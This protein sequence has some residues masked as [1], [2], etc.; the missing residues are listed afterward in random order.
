LKDLF[1]KFFSG[2]NSAL[3]KVSNLCSEKVQQRKNLELVEGIHKLSDFK[4][5]DE[6]ILKDHKISSALIGRYS[7]HEIMHFN[8]KLN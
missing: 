3:R 8:F 2:F 4:G 6:C 1:V 7:L 5:S